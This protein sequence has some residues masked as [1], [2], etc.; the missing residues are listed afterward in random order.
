MITN[1]PTM[2]Q[3]PPPP[4]LPL[5]LP[6]PPT[7]W[8]QKYPA[9]ISGILSFVQFIITIVII[10]C[11]VGS[12]LIDIVTATIYVGL[13][14]SLFF[15]IAWISQSVSS[16]CYRGRGCATYTLIIQVISMF[17]A[18]CV[19]GFDAY[20]IASPTTCFFPT[21]VC[22]SS[23]PTRG[24]FYT[25]YNFDYV[26]MPLIKAQLGAAVLM[27]LLCTAYVI[28]Y[29][30]TSIRVYRAKRPQTIYPQTQNPFVGPSAVSNGMLT[31][32]PAGTYP[33]HFHNYP[34]QFTGYPTP[35]VN[36]PVP[37]PTYPAPA[38]FNNGDTRATELACPT[39]K[40][41]INMTASKRPPM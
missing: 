26:K 15:M 3:Q 32:P 37:Y 39:C 36:Y 7:L 31:M 20:Y 13:W 4:P 41:T 38:I 24:L 19:I 12:M 22:T 30:I 17:F 2:I 1:V 14:A 16:C 18:L 5:P 40:S 27:F 21:S 11:E 28:V 8:R 6:P 29:I 23:A 10:G 25:Q 35:T 9:V 34:Q 33:A